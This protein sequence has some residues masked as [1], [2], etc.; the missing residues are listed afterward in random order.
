MR[1]DKGYPHLLAQMIR[2]SL[3]DMTCSGST[4][5]H[6][7]RGGQVFLGAQLEAVGAN[8][9]LVTITSGGND[10]GYIGDLTLASGYAGVLGKLFWKGPKPVADRNFT[11]VSDNFR[12]IAHEIRRRAPKAV[13]VF[14]SYPAVLPDYGGCTG[15]GFGRDMAD[16]GRQVAARLHDAT[17]MAAARSAAIFVDMATASTGHDACSRDPW[18]NGAAPERGAPFHPNQA[19][20]KATAAE[21]FR[22]IT[23]KR[24]VGR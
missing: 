16:T 21:V 3:V 2:L 5:D 12:E 13:V 11:K 10:V 9:R 22:I 19:G 18:V 6:I 20:A 23:E 14:I 15:L 4:T 17:R 8:T 24:P 1:S 7:L